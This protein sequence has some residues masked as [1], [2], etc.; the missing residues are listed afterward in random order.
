MG[1][2]DIRSFFSSYIRAHD[3]WNYLLGQF[4]SRSLPLNDS[5]TLKVLREGKTQPDTFTVSNL[6]SVHVEFN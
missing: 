6:G 1:A 3:G 2:F 5:V 4:A